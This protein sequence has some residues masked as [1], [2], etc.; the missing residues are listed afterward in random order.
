MS[1]PIIECWKNKKYSEL[2]LGRFLCVAHELSFANLRIN[3]SICSAV[4][5]LPTFFWAFAT[6]S[7]AGRIQRPMVDG[8][9]IVAS[10]FSADLGSLQT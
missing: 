2:A 3:F 8:W 7:E 6:L 4:R 1:L 10:S 5:G 9:T